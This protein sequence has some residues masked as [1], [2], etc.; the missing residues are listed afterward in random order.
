MGSS[1]VSNARFL[2]LGTGTSGGIPLIACDCETCTSPDPRDTRSRTGAAVQW[3]DPGGTPRTV[4]IDVTPDHKLQALRHDL[5]RCDAIL[6]THNHV[7]HIFGLDEVRRYNAVMREPIDIYAE[8][9]VL[10]SL[11][12]VYQHI[13]DK[14]RNVNDSFVATLIAS[15]I[16]GPDPEKGGAGDPV[17]LHGMRFTPVRFIH[18]RLPILGFRI[19]PVAGVDPGDDDSPFPLAYCTD[20]SAIPPRTWGELTGLRTL[21]LDALRIRKHPT[22]FSLDQA[23]HAA[24]EIR[25]GQTW[26]VHIAHEIKHD[27]VSPTLPEG[28][29]LAWD[30]L[31]LGPARHPGLFEPDAQAPLRPDE[32]G[33]RGRRPD[34]GTRPPEP[35]PG[36]GR[37]DPFE[38]G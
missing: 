7:D 6:F 8:R 28:V 29:G 15:E 19:E 18:G 38:Q 12:R 26:F 33:G 35:Q 23:V 30:G 13:F 1:G 10:D 34:A 24:G 17:E 11:Q 32:K 5:W 9:Y 22:H 37:E 20:V 3:I 14:Q 2:F 36:F 25:A 31:E 21:V 16:E 27:V 4:L